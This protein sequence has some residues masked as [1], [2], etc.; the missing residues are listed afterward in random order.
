MLW[1]MTALE[2][3]KVFGKKQRNN[4]KDPFVYKGSFLFISPP[5]SQKLAKFAQ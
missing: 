4:F 1:L 3:E 5:G 2:P